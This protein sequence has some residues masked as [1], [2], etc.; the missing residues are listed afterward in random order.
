MR[1]NRVDRHAL[2]DV[3]FEQAPNEVLGVVGR[4]LPSLVAHRVLFA[5]HLPQ[6]LFRHT[7]ERRLSTEHDI[8]HDAQAPQV[9]LARVALLQH[10]RR[11]VGEGAAT[12]VHLDVRVPHLAEAEVDELQ[13]RAALVVVEEVLQLEVPVHDAVG[14][15]VVDREEHLPHRVRGVALGK[16]LHLRD[17]VEELAALTTLHDEVEDIVALVDVVEARDVRVV[18]AKEDLN[19]GLQLRLLLLRNGRELE[20]LYGILQSALRMLAHGH[21]DNAVVAGAKDL[22]ADIVVVVDLL[23]GLVIPARERDLPASGLEPLGDVRE[24]RSGGLAAHGSRRARAVERGP[25]RGSSAHRRAHAR[26][27]GAHATIKPRASAGCDTHT[28][29]LHTRRR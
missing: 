21:P 29:S 15:D 23:R 2:F 18:H 11:D 1:E 27:A 12:D 8:G 3:D 24:V 7:P 26:A 13:V 19:L 17:A 6:L 14:V 25:R 16:P 28:R 5:Q 10:L 20:R 22:V 4:G 9:A